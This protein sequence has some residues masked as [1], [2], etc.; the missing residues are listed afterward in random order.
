MKNSPM[1]QPGAIGFIVAGGG[2]PK[3]GQL[4]NAAWALS[5]TCTFK[6]MNVQQTNITVPMATGETNNK[7]G[8][9]GDNC[10]PST[11]GLCKLYYY[12]AFEFYKILI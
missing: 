10:V 11:S 5:D 1:Y 3:V 9:G 4:Q 12:D 8:R 7:N 6:I 2:M